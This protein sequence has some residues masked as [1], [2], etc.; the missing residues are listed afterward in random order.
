MLLFLDHILYCIAHCIR[1]MLCA[2]PAVLDIT[3][4]AVL[5]ITWSACENGIKEREKEYIYREFVGNY[6]PYVTVARLH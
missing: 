3:R 1:D 4:S 2:L 6:N 5:A